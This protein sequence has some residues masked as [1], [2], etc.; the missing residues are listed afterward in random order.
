MRSH[1]RALGTALATAIFSITL[2]AAPVFVAAPAT[3][4][5]VAAAARPDTDRHARFCAK[6]DHLLK[7]LVEKGFISREEAAR[8]LDAIG[9]NTAAQ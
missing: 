5:Q 7:R 6:M 1:T 4:T 3:A 8:I 9:C 2:F